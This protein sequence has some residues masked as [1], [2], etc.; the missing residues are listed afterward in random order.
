MFG[1]PGSGFQS[2]PPHDPASRNQVGS[3]PL[4]S[5]STLSVG[6]S[7]AGADDLWLG[8][9]LPLSLVNTGPS[10]RGLR[11][12]L[13]SPILPG[14]S[15]P[16][17]VRTASPYLSADLCPFAPPGQPE[18]GRQEDPSDYRSLVDSNPDLPLFDHGDYHLSI[19]GWNINGYP[20]DSIW[21]QE[22]YAR[23]SQRRLDALFLINTRTLSDPHLLGVAKRCLIANLGDEYI[24]YVSPGCSS[25]VPG[26]NE[27]VG[28]V[29]LVVYKRVF[30][31]WT[32]SK[33]HPYPSGCAMYLAADL[34]H[35]DGRRARLI[36]VYLS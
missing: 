25:G 12:Y 27:W 35:S 16:P 5:P 19:C 10:P 18:A 32:V 30:T 9:W 20:M 36:C 1:A 6:P 21:A 24:V 26:R 4:P 17:P 31:G 34:H 15:F 3:S 28:G 23:L 11:R 8:L 14:E 22:L 33:L 29:T 7:S 13:Q 2:A